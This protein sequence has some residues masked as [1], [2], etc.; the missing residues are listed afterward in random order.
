MLAL[1]DLPDTYFEEFVPRVNDVTADD[2]GR[3]A[4]RY[5]EP[6]RMLTLIVGDAERVMPTLPDLGLG[7]PQVVDQV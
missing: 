4:G 5:L 2:L 7:E 3:A 6:S 1:H